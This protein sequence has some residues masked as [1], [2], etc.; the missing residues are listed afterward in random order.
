MVIGRRYRE[1]DLLG[2]AALITGANSGIG[3]SIAL[4]LASAGADIVINYKANRPAADALVRDIASMGQRAIAIEADVGEE[5]DVGRLFK[6]AMEY[7]GTLH[8]LVTNAGIEFG[9]PFSE[10][11]LGQWE[12]VVKTNLTGQFLCMREAARE[13]LRRGVDPK[14][15]VAAGK[16]VCISSVHQDIPRIGHANYASSKAGVMMLMRSAAR[17]LAPQKIRINAIAP[18][19]VKTEMNRHAWESPRAYER[20]CEIVPYGRIGCPDEIGQAALWLCSEAAD[21]VTGTT[22][23]VDGGLSLSLSSEENIR[24]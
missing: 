24:N 19:A 6:T 4:A 10:M 22:L 3:R 21:Y 9:A 11:T 8:I 7:L 15:S 5:D 12:S 17:E 20:L 23:R 1:G 14:L 13:F 2:Q 16:I 18:G